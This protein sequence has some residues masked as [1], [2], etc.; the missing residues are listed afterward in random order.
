MTAS[1]SPPMGPPLFCRFLGSVASTCSICREG[2]G[3][4]P[5]HHWPPCHIGNATGQACG[6]AAGAAAVAAGR[7]PQ[8]DKGVAAD[9]MPT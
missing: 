7:T 9:L 8:A 4:C 1:W 5:G 6:V 2:E 3:G